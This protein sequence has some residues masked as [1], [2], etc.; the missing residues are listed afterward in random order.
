LLTAQDCQLVVETRRGT[1]RFRLANQ[2]LHGRVMNKFH[3]NVP[4]ADQPLS[5]TLLVQG[6]V[7]ARKPIAPAAEKL[8]FTVNGYPLPAPQTPSANTAPTQKTGNAP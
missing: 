8:S 4:E 2:R 7:V 6:R 1:R 5:L 3:V